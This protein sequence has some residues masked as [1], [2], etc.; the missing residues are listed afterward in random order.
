MTTLFGRH[1]YHHLMDKKTEV[2][3]WLNQN[4]NQP[5]PTSETSLVATILISQGEK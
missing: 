4:K 3:V 5:A 1:S 2:E